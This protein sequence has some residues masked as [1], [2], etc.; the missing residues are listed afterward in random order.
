MKRILLAMLLLSVGGTGA[1][2]GPVAPYPPSDLIRNMAWH[3]ETYTNAAI[4]SDLW[5]VTWGPDDNLYTA[6]G[7]GG[8]FGGGMPGITIW[9]HPNISA[10][11][12]SAAS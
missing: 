3:W 8:G 5:P 10:K 7:D 4:G 12:G 2:S 1:W 9:T 6:W 11:S